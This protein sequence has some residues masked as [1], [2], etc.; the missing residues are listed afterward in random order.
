MEL[1]KGLKTAS[2]KAN[3]LGYFE[4]VFGDYKKLFELED[5]W[6]A[7]TVDDVQR[8]VA[9]LPGAAEAHARRASSRRAPTRGRR[10]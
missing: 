5:G 2:G 3:Q 6:N 9:T 1:V 4:V 10:K 8:V 7:V